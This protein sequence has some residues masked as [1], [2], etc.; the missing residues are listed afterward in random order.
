[1]E[2]LSPTVV[3]RIPVLLFGWL[4]I[5]MILSGNWNVVARLRESSA[6][7]KR[8]NA[9]VALLKSQP[10]PALCE[11]LLLCYFAGKSYDYDPFNATRLI[12]FGKLDANLIRSNLQQHRYGAVQLDQ[13]LNDPVKQERFDASILATMRERYVPALT[14]EDSVL[15]LPKAQ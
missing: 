7:E 14:N 1:M 4:M 12:H 11:S 6:A 3:A 2:R 9:E 15:Y 5:P 8:F 10:G 13:P